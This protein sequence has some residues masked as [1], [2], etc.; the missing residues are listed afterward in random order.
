MSHKEE[1]LKGRNCG[2][3]QEEGETVGR[4]QL[5]VI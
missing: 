5:G 4:E 2:L 3:E 1:G